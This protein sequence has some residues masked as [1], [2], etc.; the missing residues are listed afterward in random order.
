M[1][2]LVSCFGGSVVPLISATP[3]PRSKV[4]PEKKIVASPTEIP[5]RFL[6]PEGLISCFVNIPHSIS[7]RSK[8]TDWVFENTMLKGLFG[9]KEGEVKGG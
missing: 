7:L 3:T 9:P 2:K 5:R 1:Y 6:E 8:K 4:L